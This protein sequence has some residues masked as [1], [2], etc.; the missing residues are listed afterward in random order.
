MLM[1]AKVRNS[2]NFLTT[3]EAIFFICEYMEM[4]V[5]YTQHS[6]DDCSYSVCASL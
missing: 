1:D 5:L 3:K 2:R 6:Y 4:Y